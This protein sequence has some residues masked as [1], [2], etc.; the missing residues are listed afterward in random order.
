[1][2]KFSKTVRGGLNELLCC[3]WDK[4]T[5]PDEIMRYLDMNSAHTA[6][7]F[8]EFPIGDYKVNI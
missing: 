6:A 8:S 7:A 5:H 1:M 4:E 3:K 2:N